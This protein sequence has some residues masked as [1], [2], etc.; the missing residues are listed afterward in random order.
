MKLIQGDDISAPKTADL[1]LGLQK[2]KKETQYVCFMAQK[3]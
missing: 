1:A 2:S 3:L